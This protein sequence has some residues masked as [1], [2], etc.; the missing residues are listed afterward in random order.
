MREKTQL[1]FFFIE[2][3]R[4]ESF[5]FNQYF[6]RL[7]NELTKTKVSFDLFQEK[8]NKAQKNKLGKILN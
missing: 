8:P 1:T 6:Q 2:Q 5:H 4:C 3:K 7:T